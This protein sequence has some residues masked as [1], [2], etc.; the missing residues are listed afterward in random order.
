M[1][2]TSD[3]CFGNCSM[4]PLIRGCIADMLEEMA[5]G[6]SWGGINER[7]FERIESLRSP[8]ECLAHAVALAAIDEGHNL[9]YEIGRMFSYAQTCAARNAVRVEGAKGA[10]KTTI[11]KID[12]PCKWL[13]CD[14][15][16]PKKPNAKGVM[17]APIRESITGAQCWGHEFINPR[18][19][20]WERPHK[21]SHQH[22]GEPGWR[23]EWASNRRFQVAE[24]LAEAWNALRDNPTYMTNRSSVKS[25]NA[26]TAW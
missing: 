24:A 2:H 8:E 26:V 5:G 18:T 9:D 12:Q 13:Y 17:T 25:T 7:E 16:A 4:H 10:R 3:I 19:S 11:K 14:E 15:A 22:P 23:P 1:T 6:L 20:Q 21:C